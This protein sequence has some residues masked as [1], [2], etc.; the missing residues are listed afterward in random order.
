MRA[1]PPHDPRR[2]RRNQPLPVRGLPALAPIARRFGLQHQVLND[3]LLEALVA[4][5]CRGLDRKR[6][7]AVDRKLGDTG[8]SPALRSL[9]FLALGLALRLIR[10]PLH[11]GG[12]LRRTRRQILQPRDL[13]LQRLVV[14]PKPRHSLAQLLILP[15][16][17]PHLAQ[18]L[19][20]Q[21]D[22]L[23]WCLPFK[24]IAPPGLIPSFNHTLS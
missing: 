9:A 11:A 10:R 4:R 3:D 23:S 5:A 22:Q 18:Q 2:Q 6:L 20:N 1:A 7:R 8:A 15:P 24:R 14:E 16:Q 13:V 19:A 12:L 17:T 21:V